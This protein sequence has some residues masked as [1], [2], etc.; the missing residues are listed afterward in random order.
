[1]NKGFYSIITTFFFIIIVLV[2]ALGIVYYGGTMA[3]INNQVDEGLNK[4]VIARNVRDSIYY[5][6][7]KVLDEAQLDIGICKGRNDSVRITPGLIKGYRI[8]KLDLN[9]CT[10]SCATDRKC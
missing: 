8:Q 2:V 10:Q 3:Y 5:C 7:G 6:Y 4:Y 1:M 9:N